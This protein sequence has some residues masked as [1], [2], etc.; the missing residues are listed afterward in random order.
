MFHVSKLVTAIAHHLYLCAPELFILGYGLLLA[1]VPCLRGAGWMLYT[2]MSYIVTS[3]V[4]RRICSVNCA[5]LF[6]LWGKMGVFWGILVIL[7]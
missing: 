7:A 3:F 5:V 1:C 4:F 6:V 2:L